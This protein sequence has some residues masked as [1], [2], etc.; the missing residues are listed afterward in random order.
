MNSDIES[1]K[2]QITANLQIAVQLCLQHFFA[3]FF[4]KLGRVVLWPQLLAATAV[5][6][7][8]LNAQLNSESCSRRFG[9]EADKNSLTASFVEKG[10]LV[11]LTGVVVVEI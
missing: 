10:S 4:F 7:V 5:I 2:N 8:Q 1:R 6:A 11:L 3:A 9:A